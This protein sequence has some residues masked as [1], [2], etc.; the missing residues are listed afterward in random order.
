VFWLR[1][2]S[3]SLAF[4]N[5]SAFAIHLPAQKDHRKSYDDFHPGKVSRKGRDP[6]GSE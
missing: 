4:K 3:L 5:L 1:F 6:S 2:Y